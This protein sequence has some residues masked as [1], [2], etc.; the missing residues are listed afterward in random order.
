MR[1]LTVILAAV[2]LAA[3]LA[4]DNP[5]TTVERS[6]ERAQQVLNA[7]VEAI[8]GRAAVEGVKSVRIT[9]RGE[10]WPR[11]QNV[12][13]EPPYTPGSYEEETVFDLEKNRMSVEQKNRGAGFRGH[14]RIVLTGDG[15]HNFD[16]LNRTA[17]PIAAATAQQQQFAQYQRRLPSLILR[18]ALQRAGTLRYLGEDTVNGSKHH[19]ITFV[20]VDG[21]QMAL[22]VDAKTNL[23]SKYELI[24]R[25][26]SPATR[27]ARLAS[28]TT[29]SRGRCWCR[30]PSCGNLPAR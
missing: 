29:A 3:P 23:I 12:N 2:A 9:L 4:A 20:H 25:M 21:V 11:Y 10:S 1:M 18:T 17:T 22:Y 13:A 24:Y 14:A 7:A 19:A 8:G 5:E 30:R 28:V 16:L 15:G 26:L 27:R 6:H